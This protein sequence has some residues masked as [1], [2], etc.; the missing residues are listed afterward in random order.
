M[1][2]SPPL[3]E[4]PGFP[5]YL[6]RARVLLTQPKEALK[7]LAKI[8]RKVAKHSGVT[9]WSGRIAVAMR[10]LQ[11]WL[12]GEYSEVPNT[13]LVALLAALVYFVFIIDLVPD[14]LFWIGV[15]DDTA[16][17]AYVLTRFNRD[18][19]KFE[20]WEA[21]RSALKKSTAIVDKSVDNS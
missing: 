8:P 4:P 21:E 15:L 3:Q 20:A 13:T 2:E 19:E 18:L 12:K 9:Y 14:F 10:L 5:R 11:A 16:V 6:K 7:L 17:L 1:A